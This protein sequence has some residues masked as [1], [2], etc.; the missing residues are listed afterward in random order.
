MRR[1][2]SDLL[3]LR[4]MFEHLASCQQQ[5]E[6]TQDPSSIHY[7]TET[8]LR[9]LDYCRRLCLNLNRRAALQTVN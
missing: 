9:D 8:M 1:R 5:L 2:E 6:W 4:D 7:L 3:C